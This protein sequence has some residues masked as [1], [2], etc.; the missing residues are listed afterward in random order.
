MITNIKANYFLV[1]VLLVASILS[2]CQSVDVRGH[3]VSDESISQI[4]KG[5][6]NKNTV[7][8]L[9][10]TPNF[11]PEYSQN[12]W[13]YIQRSQSKRVWFDPQVL[14]QRIVKVTFNNSGSVIKAEL[15][16]GG[17]AEEV[18]VDKDST[19]TPGTEQTGVQKFVKNFGKFNKSSKKKTRGK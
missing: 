3:Y 17:H 12:T 1:I 10:G 19:A 15:I 14:V 11:V 16:E 8:D 18:V 13:Y 6:F 2:G 9:I 7:M 5:G 4:N